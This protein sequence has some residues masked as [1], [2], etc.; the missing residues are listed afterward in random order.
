ML[1]GYQREN[2]RMVTKENMQK[3]EIEKYQTELQ[4][5]LKRNQQLQQQLLRKG[6]QVLISDD[7]IDLNKTNVSNLIFGGEIIDVNELSELKNKNKYLN[8]NLMKTINE[9]KQFK[10]REIELNDTMTKQ[11]VRISELEMKT[12]GIDPDT[13]KKENNVLNNMKR[14]YDV[15]EVRLQERVKDLEGK[16]KF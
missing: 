3:K 4:E 10:E 15:K 8:E 6:N 2:E 7:T 14:E 12:E 9:N 5:E 11:R 13:Y 1:N 16:L